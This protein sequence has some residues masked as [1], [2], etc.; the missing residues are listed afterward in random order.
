VV[1]AIRVKDFQSVD[2]EL[3][4]FIKMR[5]TVLLG[6]GKPEDDEGQ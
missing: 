2:V 3:G 5:L 6:S 1:I 4:R